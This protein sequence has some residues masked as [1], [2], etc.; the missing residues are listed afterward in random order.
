MFRMLGVA[1]LL[2]AF[3]VIMHVRRGVITWWIAL[4]E[5]I[6]SMW[7]E[8]TIINWIRYHA[9]NLSEVLICANSATIPQSHVYL[10][11]N[12]VIA[13]CVTFLYL[14][15]WLTSFLQVPQ[16]S[17][18]FNSALLQWMIQKVLLH[19]FHHSDSTALLQCNSTKHP[20]KHCI[21][22]SCNHCIGFC[23]KCRSTRRYR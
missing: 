14:V 16:E 4:G 15:I 2:P 13:A 11:F 5:Y 20:C 17:I 12:S 18:Y 22:W 9:C 23:F 6:R 7:S 19:F 10:H 8:P 3:Y 1:T 21:L